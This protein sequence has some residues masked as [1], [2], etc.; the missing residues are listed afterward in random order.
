MKINN[1]TGIEG[2]LPQWS[3]ASA[4]YSRAY[5]LMEKGGYNR[6]LI[7]AL[8]TGDEEKIKSVLLHFNHIIRGKERIKR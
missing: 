1:E 7:D 2:N 6:L 5:K 4:V 3:G 8:N